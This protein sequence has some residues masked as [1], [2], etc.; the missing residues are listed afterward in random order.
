MQKIK[1]RVCLDSS[2]ATLQKGNGKKLKD[3]WASQRAHRQTYTHLRKVKLIVQK[4][5]GR[6]ALTKEGGN[7]GFLGVD[8]LLESQE[9]SYACLF[10]FVAIFRLRRKKPG[11]KKIS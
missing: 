1:P 3:E 10:I 8:W 5:W 11:K 6:R 2:V 9:V 4:L 7:K